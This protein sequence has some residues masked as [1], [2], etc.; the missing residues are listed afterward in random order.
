MY[1]GRGLDSGTES[2]QKSVTVEVR[3]N[4]RVKQ[5]MV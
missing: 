5:T 1:L 4:K 3:E 2:N